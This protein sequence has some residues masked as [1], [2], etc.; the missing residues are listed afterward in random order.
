VHGYGPEPRR[1]PRHSFIMRSSLL[2]TVGALLVSG[3]PAAGR[4]SKPVL[5]PNSGSPSATYF[6]PGY[7][8]SPDDWGKSPQ[9]RRMVR[10]GKLRRAGL[11][12][13]HI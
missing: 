9:C 3:Y 12:G 6:N 5:R 13:D 8:Y 10:K 11:G 7:R 4:L 2:A 1:I